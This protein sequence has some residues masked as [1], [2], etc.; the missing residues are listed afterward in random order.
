MEH[1]V[2][3]KPEIRGKFWHGLLISIAGWLLSGVLAVIL[4]SFFIFDR[5]RGWEHFSLITTMFL[6]LCVILLVFWLPVSIIAGVRSRKV[7]ISRS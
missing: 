1:T 6:P 4:Y 7:G 2:N 5:N 3:E